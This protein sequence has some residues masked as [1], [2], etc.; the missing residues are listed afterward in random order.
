MG[1]MLSLEGKTYRHLHFKIHFLKSSSRPISRKAIRTT[2]KRELQN[3]R[4]SSS[5]YLVL[6]DST[7]PPTSSHNGLPNSP[8]HPLAPR[9]THARREHHV[10]IH[11]SVRYQAFAPTEH[12][13]LV[14]HLGTLHRLTCANPAC[15]LRK[16]IT[17]KAK[18]T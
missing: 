4:S 9:Q 10:D 8:Y 6:S 7:P 18:R 1:R 3:P 11:S 16:L 13:C 15:I 5:F 14:S 12:G 17:M 2:Q